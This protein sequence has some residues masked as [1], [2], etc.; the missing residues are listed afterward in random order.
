MFEKKDTATD[1][2]RIVRRR[3]LK[4]GVGITVRKGTLGLGPNLSA[5]G[6]ELSLDGV[7]LRVKCE[8]KKGDEIQIGLTG[9]GRSR[10]MVVVADVRWCREDEETETFFIGAKFRRRLAYADLGLFV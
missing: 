6:E 9:I 1:D 2:R 5:G 8:M 3:P 4:S 7:Q 10:P